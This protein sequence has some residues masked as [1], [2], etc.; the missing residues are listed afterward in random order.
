MLGVPSVAASRILLQPPHVVSEERLPCRER[1]AKRER[2]NTVLHACPPYDFSMALRYFS[3]RA[4][5]LCDRVENGR[6]RRLFSL[7][8]GPVLAEVADA[9]NGTLALALR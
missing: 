9:G 6:Y 3:R 1:R 7:P 8:E 2:M 5:E 4:G